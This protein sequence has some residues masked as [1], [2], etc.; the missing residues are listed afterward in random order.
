MNAIE[1]GDLLDVNH[2]HAQIAARDAQ[3][4]NP[5]AKDAQVIAINA[6][7]NY[8][9]DQLLRTAKPHAILDPTMD[10]LWG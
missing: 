7:R 9:G 8:R 3:V 5:F 4:A 1:G 10:H 2:I 6:A